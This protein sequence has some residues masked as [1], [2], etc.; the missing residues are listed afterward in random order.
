MSSPSTPVERSV[1][2]AGVIADEPDDPTTV[3]VGDEE[4]VGVLEQ[5]TDK[6]WIYADVSSPRPLEPEDG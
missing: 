3:V 2:T 4:P 6:T 1:A 5:W